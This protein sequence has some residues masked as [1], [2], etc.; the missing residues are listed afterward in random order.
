MCFSESANSS[1]G[2]LGLNS[3]CVRCRAGVESSRRKVESG[4][5]L[6][7]GLGSHADGGDAR[8]SAAFIVS[9]DAGLGGFHSCGTACVCHRDFGRL[10]HEWGTRTCPKRPSCAAPRARLRS[11]LSRRG[12]GLAADRWRSGRLGVRLWT[13]FRT[14]PRCRRLGGRIDNCSHGRQPVRIR[15]RVRLSHPQFDL[16]LADAFLK[17]SRIHCLEVISARAIRKT[18]SGAGRPRPGDAY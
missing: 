14:G 16:E 13:G 6:T 15:P 4:R 8:P 3:R 12:I 5:G 2:R 10:G 18:E 7:Y 17:L 9:N 1:S 11:R